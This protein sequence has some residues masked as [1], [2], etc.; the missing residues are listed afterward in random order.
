MENHEHKFKHNTKADYIFCTECGKRWECEEKNV[1]EKF[2]LP[3]RNQFDTIECKG[4]VVD[5]G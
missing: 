2:Q 5:T 1:L 4:I 3:D